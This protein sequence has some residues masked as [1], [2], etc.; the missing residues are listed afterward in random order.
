MVREGKIR[1]EKGMR[2]KEV[3]EIMEKDV[4]GRLA[5]GKERNNVNVNTKRKTNLV[6]DT[7]GTVGEEGIEGKRQGNI[8]KRRERKA[9]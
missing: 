4:K 6:S 5:Q 2:G 9:K 8:S 3:K 7:K 1:E